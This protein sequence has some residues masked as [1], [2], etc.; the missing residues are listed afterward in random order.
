MIFTSSLDEI[1]LFILELERNESVES[2]QSYELVKSRGV[3]EIGLKIILA[4][5]QMQKPVVSTRRL[6]GLMSHLKKLFSYY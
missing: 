3:T 5:V 1:V 6:T 2:V 4:T